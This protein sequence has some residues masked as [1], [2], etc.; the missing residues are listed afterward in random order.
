MRLGIEPSAI[1]KVP[2][3]NEGS[4]QGQIIIFYFLKSEHNPCQRLLLEPYQFI[5]K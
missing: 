2:P 3:L 5:T 4:E 1:Y